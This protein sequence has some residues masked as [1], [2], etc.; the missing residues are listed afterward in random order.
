MRTFHFLPPA[1]LKKECATSR[2]T[3]CISG[4]CLYCVCLNQCQGT[5]TEDSG[6]KQAHAEQKA[7]ALDK[8]LVLCR[9]HIHSIFE[10]GGH[11]PLKSLVILER[12]KVQSFV[13]A[14]SPFFSSRN[15]LF[16]S[17]SNTQ[18]RIAKSMIS[19]SQLNAF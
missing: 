10:R 15:P 14:R 4:M 7:C 8:R 1:I 3:A 13:L 16:R 6:E 12:K 5:K 9:H 19:G 11:S 2:D 18:K 17:V